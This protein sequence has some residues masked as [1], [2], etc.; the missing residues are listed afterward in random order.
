MGSKGDCYD[1]AVCEAFF[2]T[3]KAELVDR[4]SWPSKHEL[5]R[6]GRRLAARGR[7]PHLSAPARR[8]AVDH[9]S[10][11]SRGT[12]LLTSAAGSRWPVAKEP[13]CDNS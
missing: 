1:N 13:D 11:Y 7:L 5:R 4:R 10:T 6:R 9:G 2:K 3:L 12:K 8:E